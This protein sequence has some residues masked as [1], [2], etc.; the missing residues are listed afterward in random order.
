M[1]TL[2]ISDPE[3]HRK[4]KLVAAAKGETM[5]EINENILSRNLDSYKSK[6]ELEQEENSEEEKKKSK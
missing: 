6:A 1:A 2:I 5:I 4:L 3:I